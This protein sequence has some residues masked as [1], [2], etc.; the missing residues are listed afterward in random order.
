[1]LNNKTIVKLKT[2][3]TLKKDLLTKKKIYYRNLFLLL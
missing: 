2:F 1:M 3:K